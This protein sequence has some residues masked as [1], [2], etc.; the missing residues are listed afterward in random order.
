MQIV[1]CARDFVEL[2]RAVNAFWPE[3][4]KHWSYTCR[5]ID[6][7]NKLMKPLVEHDGK[8]L[9]ALRG[10]DVA[11]AVR[12]NSIYETVYA[13]IRQ[14]QVETFSR[15]RK[16]F[17]AFVRVAGQV[18]RATGPQGNDNEVVAQAF[19]GAQQSVLLLLQMALQFEGSVLEEFSHNTLSMHM[20]ANRSFEN[21]SALQ[22]HS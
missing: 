12:L 2:R 5:I 1:H 21:E 6:L 8:L 16:L 20:E 15:L 9:V 10:A 22:S 18:L 19:A 17:E 14:L 4:R 13:K 11:T 3:I 7:V